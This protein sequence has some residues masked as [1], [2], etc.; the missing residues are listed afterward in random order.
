MFSAF[1]P[2]AS[3]PTIPCF[4]GNVPFFFSPLIPLHFIA[5]TMQQWNLSI[6][7]SLGK[8]W[9]LE[10]AYV[11]TKGTHL[12]EVSNSD[13]ARVASPSNPI[14][15][16]GTNCDGTKTGST[17]QCVITQNTIF[18]INARVPFLGIGPFNDENFA[19]DAN[20]HYHGLQT[21]VTHRFSSGLYVQSAY[22]FSKSI[23]DT[24]SSQ[25][26]F[27]SRFND[28]TI[29]RNTRGPSDF[30]RTHRW[31]T[32]FAYALPFLSKREG[33]AHTAF[34]DW[35][36]SGVFT[37]QSGLPFSVFD[38]A[39]GGAY[40]NAPPS[41]ATPT[42]VAG[43]TCSNALTSGSAGSRLNGFINRAAF[44]NDLPV[45]GPNALDPSSTG[46]GNVGRNCLR[47]PRQVNLDFSIGKVF[48][49]A[50]RQSLKFT[51]DFF[52][53]TNTPSFA[54][55]AVTDINSSAF[56]TITQVVGTPRLIQFSLRYSY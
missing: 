6:Q 37:L 27:L 25:V 32:T 10:V 50:E 9:S 40:G 24:S 44:S 48:K 26:A 21:T 4:T 52:N 46:F 51:T 7:R 22:T 49:F 17:P 41:L 53:L 15:V 45:D 33:M 12:R 8:N 39:G 3:S 23:D 42:F 29:A 38:S 5:P 43:S 35:Q 20:S 19:P 18:N 36:V 30:D 28:Q 34:G 14:I 47:G 13:Q 56:G 11:G 16:K 2:V 31:S 55:P 1:D 54:N